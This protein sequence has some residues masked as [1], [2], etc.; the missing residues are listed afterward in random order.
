MITARPPARP[1]QLL[2]LEA[3]ANDE[4]RAMRRVTPLALDPVADAEAIGALRA[5][6]C[7]RG[8]LP[9]PGKVKGGRLR[10][11][12]VEGLDINACGGAG[13]A[14]QRGG[15]PPLHCA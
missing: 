11:V 9:P 14:Q 13:A 6:P 8:A 12:N 7:F 10:L 2:A 15:L 5:D 3:R 1:P 4:V